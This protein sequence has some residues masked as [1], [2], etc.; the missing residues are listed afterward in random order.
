MVLGGWMLTE[1]TVT[2]GSTE[3]DVTVEKIVCGGSWV[4]I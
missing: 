2:C 3:V 1:V 4:V